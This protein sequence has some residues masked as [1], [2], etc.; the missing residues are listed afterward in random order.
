MKRIRIRISDRNKY[1]PISYAGLGGLER[2][3]ER[4]PGANPQDMFSDSFLSH[5]VKE[6]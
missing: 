3:R 1:E 6:C 4:R 5:I 2:E